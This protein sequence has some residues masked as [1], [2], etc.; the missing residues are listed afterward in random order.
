MKLRRRKDGKWELPAQIYAQNGE[1]FVLAM[2]DHDHLM[3]MKRCEKS[4]PRAGLIKMLPKNFK[5]ELPDLHVWLSER[6]DQKIDSDLIEHP[7][8]IQLVS[9]P[10]EILSQLKHT[11]Q[12]IPQHQLRIKGPMGEISVIQCGCSFGLFEIYCIEGDLFEGTRRYKSLDD[13]GNTVLSLLTSGMFPEN[14]ARE[15][16]VWND[17]LSDEHE[18]VQDVNPPDFSEFYNEE[19]DSG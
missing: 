12:I 10:K 7:A 11:Q 15:W 8:F 9:A 18:S 14:I 1:T 4:A 13:A 2:I 19:N 16:D 3:N 17:L 5:Y 6:Q